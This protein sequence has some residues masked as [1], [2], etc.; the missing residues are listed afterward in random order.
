[1]SRYHADASI[2][3]RNSEELTLNERQSRMNLLSNLK[4]LYVDPIIAS[5]SLPFEQKSNNLHDFS[6]PSEL[7]CYYQYKDKPEADSS[8]DDLVNSSINLTYNKNT[9]Y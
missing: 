6:Y 9:T 7:R 4:A 1:M 3:D 5:T 2:G 8:K